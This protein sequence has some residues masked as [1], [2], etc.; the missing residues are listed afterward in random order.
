[1]NVEINNKLESLLNNRYSRE[2]LNNQLS[3]MFGFEVEVEEYERDE[4]VQNDVPDLDDQ[5]LFS[6][7]N[8]KFNVNID[9]DLYYLKCNGGKYYITETNF[10][11]Q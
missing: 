11:N 10:E 5:L 2:E 7:E 9:V 8:E 1:M 3:Q 4:W 6:I